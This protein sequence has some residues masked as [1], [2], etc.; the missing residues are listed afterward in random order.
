MIAKL[1]GAKQCYPLA[2]SQQ[3]CFLSYT[4]WTVYSSTG[5][6]TALDVHQ[7]GTVL[8]RVGLQW[9]RDNDD[10]INAQKLK[11]LCY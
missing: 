4:I 6:F 5:Y 7:Q 10:G 2:I 3:F 1:L 11:Y 9:M 8:E